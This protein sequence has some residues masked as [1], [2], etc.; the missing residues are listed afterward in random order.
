MKVKLTCNGG[1]TGI[2]DA[3]G[4]Q[5]EAVLTKAGYLITATALRDAGAL[6][7]MPDYIFFKS[8]VKVLWQK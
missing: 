4:K 2:D 8:E 6:P 3:I 1:Y 7:C 5:L